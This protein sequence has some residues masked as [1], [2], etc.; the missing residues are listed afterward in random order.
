MNNSNLDI[1]NTILKLKRNNIL[2]TLK[3]LS[4]KQIEQLIEYANNNYHESTNPVMDDDIYDIIKEYLEEKDPNNPVLFKVGSETLGSNRTK[5]PYYLGSMDKIKPDS[6]VIDKWK[7][8]YDG[9][10]CISTK[11][12]GISILTIF[13]NN[14]I[15]MFTRGRG[16]EGGDVSHLASVVNFN[17][18]IKKMKLKNITYLA[19]RGELMISRENFKKYENE[20]ESSRNAIGGVVITKSVK[21]I[22]IKK[23][24]IDFIAFELLHP[25][26][27]A[28]Q[29]FRILSELD[30]DIANNELLNDINN[31]IL[32]D[33]LTY[34]RKYS[35]W[36]IDGI[37]VTNNELYPINESGN[38]KYSFAFKMIVTDEVAE[39]KV[40]DVLW[41]ISRDGY[42]NPRV[43][44]EKVKISGG[45]LQYTTGKNA[46]YI[47][48]NKIGLGARIKIVRSGE[49]IPEI[50]EITK[51][52]Q[53]PKLPQE[54]Y[55]GLCE[56]TATRVDLKLKNITNN[57]E[58]LL[59][60]IVHFFKTIKTKNLDIGI[61]TNLFDNGYNTIPKI[62]KLKVEDLEKLDGFKTKLSHKIINNIQESIQNV[63]LINLMVGSNVFGRGLGEKKITLIL[64]E[65]PDILVSKES[66]E[67]IK[68][69][70]ENIDGFSNKLSTLFVNNL[71]NF[72][73]FVLKL[74]IKINLR[75]EKILNKENNYSQ[76][77]ADQ[78]IVLTGFRDTE[79][80]KYILESGGKIEDNVNSK[81]NMLICQ[82]LNKKSSKK[83]KAELLNIKI[84]SRKLFISS[85]ML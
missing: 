56:W 13:N 33:K 39:V 4:N 1:Q 69:Q 49:V 78:R 65:Y 62:L 82:D 50:L 10:Y 23:G 68:L 37:I 67:D 41:N 6:Q 66:I 80:Q 84:I 15:Q 2:Q 34:Y 57:K 3:S 73:E 46:K 63:S 58:V 5:L 28:S 9:P 36:D 79:I 18:V 24:D 32:S 60:N 16:N 76:I 75:F 35:K 38:P 74:P 43:M 29:Q 26:Y 17:K 81:T 22:K 40:L 48:D 8:K 52:A 83:D 55:E 61:L 25:R 85:Y 54:Y 7:K 51:P 19:V 11:L 27:I 21:D 59:Q 47:V 12:D 30:F 64:E 14:K 20:F 31:N 77:F 72:K 71:E 44:F 45:N 53:E 42:F 70:I